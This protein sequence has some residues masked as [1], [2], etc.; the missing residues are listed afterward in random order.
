MSAAAP[1]IGA[2]TASGFASAV[3]GSMG[4]MA[5]GIGT[6]M[7]LASAPAA[8]APSGGSFLS[9]V[10]GALDKL[11]GWNASM[12]SQYGI[13]PLGTAGSLATAGSDQPPPGL[14]PQMQLAAPNVIAPPPMGDDPVAWMR[15]FNLQ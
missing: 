9:S 15:A 11:G 4:G 6:N 8:A 7:S 13:N 1:A 5:G 3:P 14:A 12:E 10:G 2:P